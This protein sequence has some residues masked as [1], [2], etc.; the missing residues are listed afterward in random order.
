MMPITETMFYV[1][2][3]DDAWRDMKAIFLVKLQIV[4]YWEGEGELIY[5]NNMPMG[6]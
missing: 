6:L 3:T 5:G 1:L 2:S 4:L